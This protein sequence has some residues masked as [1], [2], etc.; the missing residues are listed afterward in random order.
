MRE[1]FFIHYFDVDHEYPDENLKTVITPELKLKLLSWN[2]LYWKSAATSMTL[3]AGNISLSSIYLARHYRDTSTVTTI[4][5]FSLLVMM[6]L[7]RSFSMA[8]HDRSVL[9][10]RSAYMTEY[11][12]FNVLD[13]DMTTFELEL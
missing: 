3:V 11:T 6:K 7:W 8:R 1:N 5:S 2:N 4:L 10:A 13:P 12:S 9:R